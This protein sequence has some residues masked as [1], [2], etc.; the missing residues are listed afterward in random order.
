MR[1]RAK[2]TNPIQ[3]AW[4]GRGRSYPLQAYTYRHIQR[5]VYTIHNA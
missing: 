5:G 4:S 3:N 1:A 2:S